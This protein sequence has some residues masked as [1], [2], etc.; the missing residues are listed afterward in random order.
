LIHQYLS[1]AAFDAL[2]YEIFG[3]AGNKA[4]AVGFFVL[5]NFETGDKVKY[6]RDAV[7]D[8]VEK[9]YKTPVFACAA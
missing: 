6:W 1:P 7:P 8:A 3:S 2:A 5:V 4:I 9:S